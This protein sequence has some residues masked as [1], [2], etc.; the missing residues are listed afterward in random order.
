M[1]NMSVKRTFVSILGIAVMVSLAVIGVLRA[2]ENGRESPFRL[3]L[4]MDRSTFTEDDPVLLHMIVR[5]FSDRK[6]YFVVYDEL[7]TTYRPVVYTAMGREA[8]LIV[9]Y[10]LKNLS[11]DEVI[12]D[13]YPRIVEL[14][15]NETFV[16]S[17]NLKKLYT[18]E[19]ENEYRVKGF[20]DPDIKNPGTIAGGNT[21][22]FKITRS[23]DFTPRSGVVRVSREVSPSEVVLL[24]LTAEKE[25][26]WN[27]FFKYIKTENLINAYPE[28]VRLYNSADEIEKLKILEDFNKFLTRKRTDYIKEFS[29]LDEMI[30]S[31]KNI[32]YVD[33]RVRRYGPRLPFVYRYRYTLEKFQRLWLII[34]VDATVVKGE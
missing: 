31:D 18:L 17:V 23:P 20:F 15:P 33:V 10:R 6:E 26:N 14:M 30:L 13:R 9:D 22:T 12:K 16:Y 34:D 3:F 11:I 1:M 5:N 8:E 27:N 19:K 4:Y 29:V 2:D 7:Y 21:L 25:R 24:A 32:A 28:Y